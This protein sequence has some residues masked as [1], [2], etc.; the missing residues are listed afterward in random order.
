MWILHAPGKT[1]I[2]CSILSIVCQK[3]FGWLLCNRLIYWMT[4]KL[5]TFNCAFEQ[6]P[7]CC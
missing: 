4:F 1:F 5:K 3:G 6:S 2:L 7:L